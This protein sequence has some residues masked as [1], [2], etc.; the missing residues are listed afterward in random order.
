MFDSSRIKFNQQPPNLEFVD[1]PTAFLA[2]RFSSFQP[3]LLFFGVLTFNNFC[4]DIDLFVFSSVRMA[5]IRI[6][7]ENLKFPSPNLTH[8]ILGYNL[9]APIH[10]ADLQKA[11]PE[12]PLNSVLRFLLRKGFVHE[13]PQLAVQ[14][15]KYVLAPPCK[16]EL[17]D[18]SS[19]PPSFCLS[20]IFESAP[21]TTTAEGSF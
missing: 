9:G 4:F 6:L 7:V 15:H 3:E 20:V 17:C 8:L 16:K 2:F 1:R 19:F 12:N 11:C 21:C 13:E 5:A 18:P 14:A 10:K